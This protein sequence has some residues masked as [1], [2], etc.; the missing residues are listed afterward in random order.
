MKLK[1]KLLKKRLVFVLY[2]ILLLAVAFVLNR[3][4]QMLIFLLFFN[5]IQS[6][7]TWRF[8]AD[9]FESDPIKAVKYCKIITI[10]VHIIYLIFCKNLNISLY[11]N[12][13]IIIL[14]ALI[15]CLF[16]FAAER[17][18]IKSFKLCN[19]ETLI[20]MCKEADISEQVTKRLIM[21]YVEHKTI[22][23][24]AII[25]CVEEQAVKMSINR[26]KKKLNFD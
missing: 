5:F 12:L 10:V 19:Q 7:F 11:S 25:E 18:V 15:N 20:K 17:L 26:A 4:F 24:I 23:E 6:C 22:K 14:I 1:I 21:K 9:T 3:F 16:Q 13:F 2:C 8:H